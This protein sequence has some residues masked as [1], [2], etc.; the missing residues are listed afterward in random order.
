MARSENGLRFQTSIMTSH[1][2][3]KGFDSQFFIGSVNRITG[4]HQFNSWSEANKN[5]SNLFGAFN[6]NI[7]N[8]IKM[9]G[10]VFANDQYNPTRREF[11]VSYKKKNTNIYSK[12]FQKDKDELNGFS[13]NRS[14]L[15]IG[16]KYR[17]NKKINSNFSM[18]YDLKNNEAVKSQFNS[19]YEHNCM[20]IDLYLSRSFYSVSSVKPGLS[21]G[22]KVELIGLA[23]SKNIETT[24]RCNGY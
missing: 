23:R 22:L 1:R 4:S 20:A 10:N 7:F 21:V 5:K 19:R 16:T 18:I 6:F 2:N 17:F 14:E 15:A 11:Q 9:N 12:Y 13:E 24:Q 8:K 3:F